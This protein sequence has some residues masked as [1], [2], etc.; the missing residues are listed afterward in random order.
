MAT[1][2]RVGLRWLVPVV[3]AAT[4]GVNALASTAR[5]NGVT[6]SM[7]ANRYDNPFTPAGFTFSIWGVIYLGLVA[8]SLWQFTGEGARSPRTA[9]VR[10]A[11]V[12]SG[13]ANVAWLVFWHHEQFGLALGVM[14]LLG[15]ALTAIHS[16]LAMC[17]AAGHR[18]WWCV[19]APFSL[20]LGWITVAM[21]A[22]LTVVLA[23]TGLLPPAM[24]EGVVPFVM[25]AAA[26]SIGVLMAWCRRDAVF[27]A[28]LA[29]AAFGIA[30]KPGQRLSLQVAAAVAAVLL[31][32]CC[33]AA[34][35]R[36]PRA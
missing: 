19:D 35:A 8:F 16:V 7:V 30:A 21:L 2:G 34:L 13:A 18:E 6:T 12:F 32:A 33:G 25:L 5:I 20:Y 29:W 4:I 31:A 14:F 36:R 22:N 1:E 3:T 24:A 17:P 11:Y 26:T 23:S 9:A 10:G 15:L 28:A 27:V